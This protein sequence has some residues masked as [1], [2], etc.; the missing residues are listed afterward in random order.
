MERSGPYLAFIRREIE[1]RGL[2]PELIYLPIIESQYL[3][4]ALSR[5]GAAGLWQF[6][7]NSIGPFDMKINDWMDER[8]DFWKSTQGALRKLEENYRHLDDWALALAAYNTGLGGVNRV[9]RN[10]GIRDYWLLS[11]KKLLRNETVHYVPKFLAAAY[12]LSNSRRFGLSPLWPQDPQWVRVEADRSA[13]LNILAAESGV[14]AETL[15]SAN[16]ELAFNVTPPGGNYYLK[17]R[18]ADAPRVS[19]VL[20]Q[21]DLRLINYYF[22]T[23]RS[24]DTLLA[25]ANHYGITVAQI[26]DANPGTQAR[27]LRLGGRLLIPAFREAGP[28]SGSKTQG[29]GLVFGGNHL[30]KRGE[31]LWSIALA[32][33]VDP[34]VLAE[35]NGMGL[36]DILREGRSL[37]T[38]IK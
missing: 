21:R 37:K 20:A 12:I 1:E 23:I 25:L 14:D 15:K 3:A 11:E 38:P 16:R 34:E 19:A 18:A 5:S 28:Y 10:S 30:V 27:Y 36:N 8:R 2:P 24:G 32:Y 7:K 4:S 9:I 26:L 33:E 35:A 31:T 29:E 13:D 17:V 6:M 22:H